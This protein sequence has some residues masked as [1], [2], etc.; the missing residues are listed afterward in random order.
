MNNDL[1]IYEKFNVS[2]MSDDELDFVQQQL[3]NRKIKL[4]S[5]KVENIENLVNRALQK[6]GI[7]ETELNNKIEDLHTDNDKKLEVTINQ[8]RVDKNK[9]GFGSQS[10]FGIRFRVSI[11]SKTVGKLFKVIGIAK[12]S[13]GKTE[14]KREAI[15]SGKAT[16]EI[17]NGYE[18][19]RWHH[20]K[21]LKTLE[22]WLLEHDL[23]EEFYS[24]DKEKEL[25]QFIN[26]LYDKYI[27]D[28]YL[29][30]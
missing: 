20:E 16:T 11:G 13:K 9:W 28:E 15:M 26:D 8:M 21:C 18:S 23:L 25:M 1:S 2:D 7:V 4:L 3:F 6:V 27:D 17:I 10:D 5:D 29:D 24:I 14:P 19:V 12:I 30:N 22:K